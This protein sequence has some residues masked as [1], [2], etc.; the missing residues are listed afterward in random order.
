MVEVGI[1]VWH[2]RKTLPKALDSLVAQTKDMFITCLSIDGDGENYDDI[3]QEYIRRGLK[4]RVIDSKE[5]GGPGMARQRVFD[6]T[7]CD[8]VMF[9]D[10]DDML[11]PRAVEVLYTQS[12]AADF[13]IVRSSFIREE[14]NKQDLFLPQN[15]GTITWF[16]GKIYKVKYIRD[17]NLRFLPLRTDEDAYFNLV[18]WNSTQKRGEISE[19]TYL[20]RFNENS[21]TRQ[22]KSKEYFCDT[23]MN[24]ITSQVEGL[25][26]LAK[27]GK[28]TVNPSLVGQTLINIYN[29]YMHARFYKIPPDAMDECLMTLKAEPWMQLF[30]QDLHN[31]AD[32]AKNLRA[33]DIYDE[34]Y[35]VFYTEPINAWA[36]RLLRA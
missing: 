33:G 14:K 35:V 29:Y 15:A 3:I 10:S 26:M 1:P 24:Y 19:V 17:N 21:L 34:K 27:L 5:N 12:K 4:I 7:Q 28:G 22:R 16:H 2:A 9:M 31:W 8:Y 11:M 25:K 30:L 6:T 20:W 13:D 32:I 18:A 36:A 23:Y